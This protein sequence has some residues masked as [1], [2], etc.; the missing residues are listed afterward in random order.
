MKRLNSSAELKRYTSQ[1]VTAKI[2]TDSEEWGPFHNEYRDDESSFGIPYMYIVRSDG[3]RLWAGSASME[4]PEMGKILHEKLGES[5]S[6]ISASQAKLLMTTKEKIEELQELGDIDGAVAQ[7]RK[8]A[9]IGPIGEIPSFA[10]AA[11]EMNDVA[12]ALISKGQEQL[13]DVLKKL[14]AVKADS[15]EADN[16]AMMSNFLDVTDTYY[17]LKPMK[18]DFMK[19][20]KMIKESDGLS[21]LQ[22]DLKTIRGSESVK[23]NSS[24]GK[25]IGKLELIIEKRESGKVVDIANAR[26]AELKEKL[27]SK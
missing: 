12:S 20:R 2:E 9:K 25:A 26:I 3:T 17:G 1:F 7:L 8:V 21:A 22:R 15:P 19:A 23:S 16:V 13:T 18:L 14:E 24:I 11:T 10:K 27:S 5:G 6:V 4:I